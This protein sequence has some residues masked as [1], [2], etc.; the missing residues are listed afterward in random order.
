[1]VV[2][3]C[4]AVVCM[5]GGFSQ[6]K[7]QLIQRTLM[8]NKKS[9]PSSDLSSGNIQFGRV[10]WETHKLKWNFLLQSVTL[11]YALCF[12]FLVV[13]LI[14]FINIIITNNP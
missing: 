6:I 1:M 5:E 13:Q 7:S 11:M 2:K 10:P 12:S 8:H 4:L 3:V 9:Q 14:V